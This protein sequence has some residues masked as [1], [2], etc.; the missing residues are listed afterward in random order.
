MKTKIQLNEREQKILSKI[1]NTILN[2]HIEYA[3]K[4]L[5]IKINSFEYF[6]EL[7]ERT[8]FNIEES[9]STC[10]FDT[11]PFISSFI[12]FSNYEKTNETFI[13]ENE[14]KKDF[15]SNTDLSKLNKPVINLFINEK[16]KQYKFE[17]LNPN[18]EEIINLLIKLDDFNICSEKWFKLYEFITNKN[19]SFEMF[20]LNE[21][22]G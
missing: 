7:R 5:N 12:E 21:I 8:L 14:I 10:A 19:N 18:C 4:E 6:N 9:L 3:K 22:K 17:I 15:Y 16:N 1:G 2:L 13:I 11:N 20:D